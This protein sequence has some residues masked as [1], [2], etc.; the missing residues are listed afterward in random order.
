MENLE[1]MSSTS[2]KM[3]AQ[4]KIMVVRQKE[5]LE[6]QFSLE[7]KLEIMRTKTKILKKQVINIAKAYFIYCT[8]AA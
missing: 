6:E 8:L 2:E 4:S 3:D 5:V 1:K 7:P